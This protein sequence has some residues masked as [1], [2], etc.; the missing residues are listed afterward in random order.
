[1]EAEELDHDINLQIQEE[2]DANSDLSNDAND[3]IEADGDTDIEK[4]REEFA[5]EAQ[6]ISDDHGDLGL[7]F[8]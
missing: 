1:M 6:K 4:G 2:L 8:D 5:K 3:K 7:D